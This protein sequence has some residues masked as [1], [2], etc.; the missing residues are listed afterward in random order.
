MRRYKQK[1]LCGECRG[2]QRTSLFRSDHNKWTSL[3]RQ[4]LR[5][6]VRDHNKYFLWPHKPTSRNSL[7]FEDLGWSSSS[8]LQP[9]EYADKKREE[10]QNFMQYCISPTVQKELYIQACTIPVKDG[11]WSDKPEMIAADIARMNAKLRKKHK[12]F[13]T[14]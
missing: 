4:E 14:T 5:I 6:L 12:H 10:T 1:I 11:T 13:V 3:F 7:S 9:G 8:Y 2:L